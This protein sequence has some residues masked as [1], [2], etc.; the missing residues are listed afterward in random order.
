MK[1]SPG[2]AGHSEA[3]LER[4]GLISWY[5]S[6]RKNGV[7]GNFIP[8]GCQRYGQVTEK[9]TSKEELAIETSSPDALAFDPYTYNR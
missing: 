2:W 1:R 4:G 7:L 6:S 9:A 5:R 8:P 3:N